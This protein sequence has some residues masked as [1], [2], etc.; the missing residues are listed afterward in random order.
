MDLSDILYE[1]NQISDLSERYFLDLGNLFPSLLNREG[2]S[3]LQNLQTVVQ[4]L[5]K[6]NEQSTASEKALFAKD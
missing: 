1:L 3:S 4:Q 5:N 6:G 2:S